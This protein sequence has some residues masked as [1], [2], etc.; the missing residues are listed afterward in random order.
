MQDPLTRFSEWLGRASALDRQVMPEP[1]AFSLATVSQEGRPSVRMLLLKGVSTAGFTFFTN[2]E[3]RKG[4]ELMRGGAAALCFHW[5]PLELQVRVEG[6]ATRVSEAEADEYFATRPRESQLGAWA[7]QQSREIAADGDLERRYAE[8]EARF[9]GVD[10][11]R[12]KYW[13]GFLVIPERIEFWEGR[14]FR[15]HS[16]ELYSRAQNGWQVTRLYP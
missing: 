4:E 9:R 1:T 5:A 12:P 8:T 14:P 11:P 16:R 10:V 2:L 3:S 7:S 6:R 15:M 13:S